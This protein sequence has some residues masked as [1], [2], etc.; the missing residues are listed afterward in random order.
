MSRKH[1]FIAILC[2]VIW[3]FSSLYWH[4]LANMNAVFVLCNRIIFSAIFSL[5]VL[6]FQKKGPQLKSVLKNWTILKSLIPAA[7][8]ISVNWGLYIWAMGSEHMLDASLGYYMSPL[9]I[10]A[11]STFVFKEKSSGLK[12]AAIFIAV[13]GVFV[14]LVMYQTVPIVGLM[15]AFSFTLYGTFKKHL[16]L[17]PVVSTCVESIVLTPVALVVMFFLMGDSLQALTPIDIP[18]LIGT[19]ILTGL[20]MILFSSAVNNIPYIAVGFTQYL[21]PSITMVIGLFLGEVFTPEKTVLLGF[22][23]VSIVVYSVGL[24]KESRTLKEANAHV[25]SINH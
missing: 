25:S 17:D 1:L 16:N 5:I 18:L 7:F 9:I 14:S 6:Y 15:L 23:L 2:N 22:I 13:T 11:I 20:P 8:M 19:G 24:V 10:F 3:G 4:M 12:L 21:S